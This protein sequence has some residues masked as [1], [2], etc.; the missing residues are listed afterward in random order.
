VRESASRILSATGT[1]RGQI[2]P[3]CLEPENMN[4]LFPRMPFAT[5]AEAEMAEVRA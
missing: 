5:P 2:P 1:L 3:N 4:T